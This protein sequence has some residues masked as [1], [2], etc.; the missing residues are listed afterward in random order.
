MTT[1]NKKKQKKKLKLLI[2]NLIIKNCIKFEK[3]NC[4]ILKK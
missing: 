4:N 3:Y 1:F 2:N